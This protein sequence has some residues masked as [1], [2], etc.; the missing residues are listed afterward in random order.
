MSGFVGTTAHVRKAP[1]S[2]SIHDIIEIVL[3]PRHARPVGMEIAL[4][5]I[6]QIMKTRLK[7]QYSFSFKKP[8]YAEVFFT[9]K[10]RNIETFSFKSWGRNYAVDCPG[11]AIAFRARLTGPGRKIRVLQKRGGAPIGA[12]HG[13]NKRFSAFAR[14]RKAGEKRVHAGWPLF[15]SVPMGENP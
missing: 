11:F 8:F 15:C 7:K 3:I 10:K 13:S 1:E 12:E 4:K 2:V 6:G 9:I 14:K 5:P